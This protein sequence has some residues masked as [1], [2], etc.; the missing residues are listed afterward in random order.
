MNLGIIVCNSC[1]IVLLFLLMS[2][3]K[4]KDGSGAVVEDEVQGF[5]FTRL[6]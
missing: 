3:D 4:N 5:V 1:E 2:G 6:R